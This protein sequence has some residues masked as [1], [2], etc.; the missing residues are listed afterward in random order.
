MDKKG[1]L[2]L[3]PVD[4]DRPLERQE[5]LHIFTTLSGL[6]LY[7]YR[8]A[9]RGRVGLHAKLKSGRCSDGFLYSKIVLQNPNIRAIMARQLVFRFNELGLSKPDRAVGIPKG[10]TELGIDVASIMGVKMAKMAKEDGHIKMITALKPGETLLLIEDFCTKGTGFSEAVR[11]IKSKQPDVKIMPIELVIVNRG[12]LKE[13]Q[14]NDAE[15]FKIVAVAEHRI[16]DW[17]PSECPLCK[18]G[19]K[20]IK[21][22]ATEDNWR[23]ITTSQ[24]S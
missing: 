23:I 19:S 10:A 12:G 22:K 5:I 15:S 7:D 14:V 4:V 20:R 11:D 9:Q 17:D 21:P 13:I 1:L 8:A 18:M 16:N 6:W 24:L 3:K 2:N